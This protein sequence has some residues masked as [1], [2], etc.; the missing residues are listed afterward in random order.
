[1]DARGAATGTPQTGHRPEI[2]EVETGPDG[3]PNAQTRVGI[4]LHR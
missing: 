1:M 4:E 2:E 3:A